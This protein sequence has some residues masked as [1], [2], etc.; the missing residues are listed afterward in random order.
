LLEWRIEIDHNWSWKPGAVGR[1]L[2]KYLDSRTWGEF[3]NTY[4]GEDIDENWDALFKTTA[5]CRRIALEVG[6]APGYR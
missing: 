1:G 2:K 6:E 3:A 5:L 4:V